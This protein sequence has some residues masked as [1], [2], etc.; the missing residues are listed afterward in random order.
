MP[1]TVQKTGIEK[2]LAKQIAKTYSHYKEQLAQGLNNTRLNNH[3]YVDGDAVISKESYL[4]KNPGRPSLIKIL[5]DSGKYYHT[6]F[7]TY[8]GIVK[9][10][11]YRRDTQSINVTI[12]K[13]ESPQLI[14]RFSLER[15]GN[16][17]G[18]IHEQLPPSAY[19]HLGGYH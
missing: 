8:K 18:K 9:M 19:E 5:Y 12:I 2:D 14:S 3:I 15:N 6:T 16:Y 7:K 13:E 11:A 10:S 1:N 17:T 4:S